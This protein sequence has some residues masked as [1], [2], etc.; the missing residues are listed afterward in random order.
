M[1]TATV[2]T[3]IPIRGFSVESAGNAHFKE[4]RTRMWTRY[5]AKE[6]FETARTKFFAFSD[7]RM[8]CTRAKMPEDQKKTPTDM[9]SKKR[10]SNCPSVL[11]K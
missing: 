1:K 6:L 7:S 8:C 10:S 3:G 2:R 5:T 4:S 11:E 9:P